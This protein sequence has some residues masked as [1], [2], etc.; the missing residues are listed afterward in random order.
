MKKFLN[1]LHNLSRRMKS[2]GAT[3]TQENFSFIFTR[4]FNIFR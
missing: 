1:F 4:A 2:F 3:S